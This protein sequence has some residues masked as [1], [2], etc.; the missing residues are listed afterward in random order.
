MLESSLLEIKARLEIRPNPLCLLLN[1]IGKLIETILRLDRDLLGRV[2]SALKNLFGRVVRLTSLL[3]GESGKNVNLDLELVELGRSERRGGEKVGKSVYWRK[4]PLV[5]GDP[6]LI[7]LQKGDV[8]SLFLGQPLFT[9][10]GNPLHSLDIVIGGSPTLLVE[11]SDGLLGLLDNLRTLRD[12]GGKEL[13]SEVVKREDTAGSLRKKTGDRSVSAR[14]VV[15]PLQSTII[16]VSTQYPSMSNFEFEHTYIDKLF[17]SP[18]RVIGDRVL[19]TL[20][21]EFDSREA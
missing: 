21:E 19:G 6:L 11:G 9:L 16:P 1:G 17:G 8:P 3:G 4:Y 18:T 13:G 14:L 12:V 20:G 15:D 5:K 10:G 7:W 2:P